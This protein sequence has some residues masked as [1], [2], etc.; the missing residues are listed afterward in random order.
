MRP[1]NHSTSQRGGR[2][3][4][5]RSSHVR[6]ALVPSSGIANAYK[7]VDEHWQPSD[8]LLG[9]DCVPGADAGWGRNTQPP[10]LGVEL[11][12]PNCPPDY[13]H[14]CGVGCSK[15]FR[16]VGPAMQR[17]YRC[18]TGPQGPRWTA[19]EGQQ[20]EC[21]RVCPTDPEE[22]ASFS[23]HCI[24]DV[25]QQ[26]TARCDPGYS[27]SS[28]GATATYICNDDGAWVPSDG[29]RLSCA[30]RG[31]P[32]K[33]PVEHAHTCS[34]AELNS[35]CSTSCEVNELPRTPPFGSEWAVLSVLFGRV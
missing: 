27:S 6:A 15:G 29:Q 30:L 26:C 5:R 25:H 20:L 12:D 31:C 18:S 32:E 24:H 4:R 2:R 35:T 3:A 1:C 10:G 19:S 9:M 21:V 11:G 22:Y 33:Q 13:G 34:S 14:S 17:E 23:S 8:N 28:Q 16:P 7:C